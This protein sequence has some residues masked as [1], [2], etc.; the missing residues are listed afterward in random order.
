MN[1]WTSWGPASLRK[2][3]FVW[4]AHT[5]ARSVFPVPGGPYSNAPENNHRIATKKRIRKKNNR[6]RERERK[7]EREREREREKENVNL[8]EVW[9]Q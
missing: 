5:L 1:I 9:C 3:D 2:V 6:E 7:K 8:L 4:F